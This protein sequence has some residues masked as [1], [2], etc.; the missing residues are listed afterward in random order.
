MRKEIILNTKRGFCL[1]AFEDDSITNEVKKYGEYDSNTLN[2]LEEILEKI[3]PNISLDIGANIGNHTLL[4]AQLSQKLISFEPVDFIFKALDQNIKSNKLS[5]TIA[6]NV[7]L[8]NKE[9]ATDI[10]IPNN[11][12]LGSSSITERKGDGEALSVVLKK[13][14][15]FLR[16]YGFGSGV[17]FI[18]IDVEGH[19]AEAL[20]GLKQT[21]IS[22]QTLVLMEWR[23]DRTLKLFNEKDLFN[24]LFRGYSIYSLTSMDNKKAH[25]KSLKGLLSRLFFKL[26]LNKWCLR[27]FNPSMHY[28]NIFLVPKRHKRLFQSFRIVE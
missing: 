17:D 21:I 28:S 20:E 7:G 5:N 25:P 27:S 16:G 3:K 15:D 23:T 22:N 11:G 1:H 9:M 13:G 26:I 10:F 19:E 18:K 14:D 4:I 24:V 6:F 12:N 8:S 2:S